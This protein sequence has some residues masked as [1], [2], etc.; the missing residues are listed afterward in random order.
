MSSGKYRSH[1]DLFSAK[2]I[3]KDNECDI[4]ND[5]LIT[6]NPYL[7]TDKRHLIYVI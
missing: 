4:P 6:S 7:I 5:T 3:F 2:G 1:V